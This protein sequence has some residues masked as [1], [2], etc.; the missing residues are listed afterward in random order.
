MMAIIQERDDSG[1]DQ[2][3]RGGGGEKWL[4]SIYILKEEPAR[5]GCE[6]KDKRRVRDDCKVFVR[7]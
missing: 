5:L 3:R 2:V 1:S 7:N 4:D 6:K